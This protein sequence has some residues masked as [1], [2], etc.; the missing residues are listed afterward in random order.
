MKRS[1]FTFLD[2]IDA[3]S[4]RPMCEAAK[5][6]FNSLFEGEED[7]KDAETD[8]EEKKPDATEGD[9][10]DLFGEGGNGETDDDELEGDVS[11]NDVSDDDLG[12]DAD[13]GEL[14]GTPEDSPSAGDVNDIPAT[15][16]TV[17]PETLK[18]ELIEAGIVNKVKDV[19]KQCNKKTLKEALPI[20]ALG[21]VKFMKSKQYAGLPKD[22]L[23]AIVV[24]IA[25]ECQAKPKAQEQNPAQ[26]Q[27]QKP[28]LNSVTFSSGDP[29]LES[30]F[31]NLLAAGLIGASAA[32]G[33]GNPDKHCA[34]AWSP[35]A[36]KRGYEAGY[37]AAETTVNGI[38][39][40]AHAVVSAP[41]KIAGIVKGWFSSDDDDAKPAEATP[42]S[43]DS[44]SSSSKLD[45]LKNIA[46][47]A[48]D[49]TKETATDAAEYAKDAAVATGRSTVNAAKEFGSSMKNE[50][51]K[52]TAN[53]HW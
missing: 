9:D 12:D 34:D 13:L 20:I 51:A 45:R 4:A 46:G 14:T 21:V 5:L 7:G 32:F 31:K 41:G 3:P 28:D 35:D 18:K 49:L 1:L 19:A 40:G 47:N 10:E 39:D 26:P 52:E 38:K 27:G 23:K 11:D 42:K 2:S 53:N 22:S 44:Q 17:D 48:W 16:T 43:S 50:M 8:T 15:P 6:A 33:G 36:C 30:R 37:N 29:L 25:K 24:S